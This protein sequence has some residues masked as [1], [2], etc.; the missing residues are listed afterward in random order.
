MK[1]T[2]KLGPQEFEIFKITG[3]VT[4]YFSERDKKREKYNRNE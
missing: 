2:L 3:R 4:A 1:F